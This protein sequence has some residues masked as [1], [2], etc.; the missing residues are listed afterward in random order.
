MDSIKLNCNNLLMVAS[1]SSKT[2]S[3][4]SFSQKNSR[5]LRDTFVAHREESNDTFFASF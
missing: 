1:Q 3:E 5:C 4:A 2:I